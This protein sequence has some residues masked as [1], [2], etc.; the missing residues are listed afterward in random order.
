MRPHSFYST[1]VLVGACGAAGA[2]WLGVR[3][4]AAPQPV[5][6]AVAGVTTPAQ[7]V[8]NASLVTGPAAAERAALAAPAGQPAQPSQGAVAPAAPQPGVRD[9]S[10]WQPSPI[11]SK[12][13]TAAAAVGVAG[14]SSSALPG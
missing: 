9:R 2:G 7:P 10:A 3:L 6:L 8:V 4:G 14:T 11:P 12:P 5:A 13:S 1:I